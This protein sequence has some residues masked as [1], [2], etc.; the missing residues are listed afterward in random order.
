MVKICQ[1]GLL[2]LNLKL[3]QKNKF[4]VFFFLRGSGMVCYT[5]KCEEEKSHCTL[6]RSIKAP[7]TGIATTSRVYLIDTGNEWR[8][9]DSRTP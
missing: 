9:R 1:T 7:L 3:Y 2:K 8:A 5:S 6:M 4:S